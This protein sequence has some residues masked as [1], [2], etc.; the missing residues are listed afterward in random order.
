M[1]SVKNIYSENCQV[2]DELEEWKKSCVDLLSNI[3]DLYQEMKT[4]IE[5]KDE[6]ISNLN[7]INEDLKIYID[8]LEKSTTLLHS[9][10]DISEVKRKERTLKTLLSRAEAGLWFARSFGLEIKSMKVTEIKTGYRCI[11]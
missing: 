1:T 9:G 6:Q 4:A 5:E 3:R 10:K 11:L 2:R 8:R 7:S